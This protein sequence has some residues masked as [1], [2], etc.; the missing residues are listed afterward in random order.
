MKA[1]FVSN[2]NDDKVESITWNNTV[3][4]SHDK[5]VCI[6]SRNQFCPNGI[7]LEIDMDDKDV[8]QA[9]LSCMHGNSCSVSCKV[10][11]V[12]A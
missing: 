5:D 11:S 4:I 9:V 6:E 7:V 3:C 10:L 1:Y 8:I 2:N 12:V